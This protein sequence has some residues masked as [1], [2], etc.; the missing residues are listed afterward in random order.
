MM[1][2]GDPGIPITGAEIQT[3][4]NEGQFSLRYQ[5]KLD[6]ETLSL[7][8]FEALI[9]WDHP[10]IGTIYPDQFI[11]V[12]EESGLIGKIT[13]V[14]VDQAFRWYTTTSGVP[15][16][17]LSINISAKR[18]SDLDFADWLKRKCLSAGIRPDSII[19]EISEVAVLGERLHALDMFTRLRTKGFRVAIDG[20]GIG[21]A[22]LATLA[23]LPF[24]EIKIDKSFAMAA[25]QSPE[26]KA[27]L[28]STVQTSHSLDLRVVAEG[29]E[30]RETLDYLRNMGCDFVHGYLVA[31]PMTGEE[32]Q[33]WILNRRRLTRHILA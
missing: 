14:V 19:L 5:P 6:C 15:G 2:N 24:T 18:L 27:F 28:K 23:K 22:T 21:H 26:A 33:D 25:P 16:L 3:A 29:V 9:R 11:R 12:A 32:A 4:I 20:Y 17:S 7:K 31:R 13:E 10:S 30:D 1:A 8:G